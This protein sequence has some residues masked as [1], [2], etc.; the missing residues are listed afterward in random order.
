ME[1]LLY[2]LL[3]LLFIIYRKK[4]P[5]IHPFNLFG[6][7]LFINMMLIIGYTI[8]NIGAIVRYRSIF[9]VLLICPLLCNIDWTKLSVPLAPSPK[10]I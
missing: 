3:I 6:F 7:A 2:Q 4:D 10:K 8:P 5:Q 9:W 1:L